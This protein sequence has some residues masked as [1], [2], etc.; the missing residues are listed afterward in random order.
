M[1]E[2]F[3]ITQSVLQYAW[4]S[5]TDNQ[6]LNIRIRYELKKMLDTREA[7]KHGGKRH[8]YRTI[9]EKYGYHSMRSIEQI[10]Q[11]K[12]FRDNEIDK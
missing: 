9:Q 5:L 11:E 1:N 12:R 3:T 10:A 4:N 7:K 6:K 2:D 8:V